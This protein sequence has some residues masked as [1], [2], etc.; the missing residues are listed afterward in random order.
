MTN[1][2]GKMATIDIDGHKV[3]VEDG[4]TIIQAADR[5]GI[6]IPRFCYHEKLSVAANCR[7][8]L[9][10]VGD[11]QKPAPACA[12]PIKDGMEVH[13]QS[14]VATE[15]QKAVMEFLL[16]NHPLDCPVCDQGG[17]CELQDLSMGYGADL[18]LFESPKRAVANPELGPLIS[19]EMTRCIHCTRCVRFGQEI[20]GMP[21]LGVMY[22]GEDAAITTYVQH[23][24]QSE[25]SGNMIDVCPVG[26]LTSKPFR[27]KARAWELTETQGVAPHDCLGSNIRLGV[28]RNQLLRV[29]PSQNEAINEVWI[30]DRDRFSYQGIHSQH[31][32]LQPM[33]KYESA[34]Q[35]VEWATAFKEVTKRLRHLINQSPQQVGVIS[36]PQATLEEQYLLQKWARGFGINNVDHRIKH[37]D[38]TTDERAPA[39]PKSTLKPSE[40]A[41]QPSILLVGSNVRKEQPIA[42]LKVRQAWQNDAQ[43]MAV[44]IKDYD[45][46]FELTQQLTVKPQDL[47]QHIA[48]I[49]KAVMSHTNQSSSELQALLGDTAPTETETAIAQR[50]INHPGAIVVGQDGLHHLEAGA[51]QQL[52]TQLAQLTD[53]HLVPL[54]EG[55]NAAGSC[56]AGMLPHREAGGALADNPGWHCQKM[57]AEQLSAYVLMGLEPELDC[58]NSRTALQALQACDNVIML[59]DFATEAVKEYADIILPIASFGETSGTYVNMS[60]EWQ[61]FNGVVEPKGEARPAWKVLRVLGNFAELEGFDYTSSQQVR[62][63][64]WQLYQQNN[65]TLACEWQGL[66]STLTQKQF[67]SVAMEFIKEIPIY[68]TDRITRQSKPLQAMPMEGSDVVIKANQTT[69]DELQCE[70]GELVTL[71]QQDQESTLTLPIKIDNRLNDYVLSINGASSATLAID[72]LHGWVKARK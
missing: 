43:V 52:L 24:V 9:V 51:I 38:F 12:T 40:I 55:P 57:L 45:F 20:A 49:T 8:C 54:T 67:D 39:W 6:F 50:L 46:N 15:A 66:P 30:S 17:Q 42:S 25:L 2:E 58:A 47:L 36:S 59:T 16:I 63:E 19:T 23:T 60:G 48:G 37:M 5:A 65:T 28:L 53:C 21:E 35:S 4:E 3:E 62:D 7:M 34:W 69:A 70:Q 32:V 68:A 1:G 64:I 56:I 61:S 31:R 44:N 72:G 33:I 71:T 26:A 11:G 29:T 10:Q 18:S 41:E 14:S 13:T 22:R 27:F